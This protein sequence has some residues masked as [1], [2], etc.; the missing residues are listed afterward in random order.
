MR[1]LLQGGETHLFTETL[2]TVLL[3]LDLEQ[4]KDN[5]TR[6]PFRVFKFE[7]L[8]SDVTGDC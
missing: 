4:D 6:N 1:A 3:D 2:S 8:N 7:L 5:K